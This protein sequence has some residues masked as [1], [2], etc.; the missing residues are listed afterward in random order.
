MGSSSSN[1][2]SR[3][4]N[5]NGSE[6]TIVETGTQDYI[7]LTDMLRSKEGDF[8]IID[9]LRNRN[10]LEF[11][12][13]WERVHNPDFNYG[14]F[15]TI[16][17]MAGLNNFKISVKEWAEK[18]NAIGIYARSGRYGGTYAHKDIA[19]KFAAWISPEFE[20]FLIK[21]Y[22]RLKE[23]EQ[24]EG[25][26][27]W[28]FRRF[29]SK[30][31]YR[32]QTDAIEEHLIPVS[33]LPKEK[34]GIEYAQEADILNL[35][36][37]G[38]TAKQWQEQNPRLAAKGENI[39]DSATIIQLTVLANMETINALMIKGGFS[40]VDRFTKLKEYAQHQFQT[41][42]KDHRLRKISDQQYALRN[43]SSNELP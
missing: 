13:I 1:K 25:K 24:S 29:L 3:K 8:F 32:V 33:Q 9:W 11:M 23:W 6:I 26:R 7:C 28:D 39:R 21:D 20:V 38:L 4:L 14:E 19:F 18:T 27:E 41:L 12:G 22:Q 15:A 35:A 17:S 34:L 30:V 36:L 16:K 40:K 10:T 37:F 5:V 2:K 43:P 31:N 42:L